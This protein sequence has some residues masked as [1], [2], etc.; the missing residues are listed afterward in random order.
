MTNL[1]ETVQEF[2]RGLRQI[3]DMPRFPSQEAEN[4]AAEQTY[5]PSMRSLCHWNTPIT[6]IEEVREA[7]RLAFDEDAVID[8]IAAAPLRAALE[9]LERITQNQGRAA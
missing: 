2:R 3:A 6:S 1:V 9:Y 4:E 7:I 5:A 8:Q